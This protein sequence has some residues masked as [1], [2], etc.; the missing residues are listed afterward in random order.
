MK[1]IPLNV[2]DKLLLPFLFYFITLPFF[3][4]AQDELKGK[5]TIYN[6]TPEDYQGEN[7]NWAVTQGEKGVM[8]F[9]NSVGVVAY[10]GYKWETIPVKDKKLIRSLAYDKKN[11]RLYVGAT[12]ELGYISANEKGKLEYQS[13]MP[14]LDTS[15]WDFKGVWQ[16]SV[17]DKG[18]YFRSSNDIFYYHDNQFSVWQGSYSYGDYVDGQYYAWSRR[19]GLMAQVGDSL[20]YVL[21]HEAY[22]LSS[23]RFILPFQNKLLIGT[24]T[25]GLFTYNPKST[26]ASLAFQEFDMGDW[27]KIKNVQIYRGIIL[28]DNHIALA[29]RQSGLFILNQEGKIKSIFDIKAGLMDENVRHA[30]H[31]EGSNQ[32]WLALN[33]GIALVEYNSSIQFFD[34]TFGI[35]GS[36]EE[37]FWYPE[38]GKDRKLYLLGSLGTYR[39]ENGLFRLL[40]SDQSWN[41][42]I[43]K[44]PDESETKL[45]ISCTGSIKEL[46]NDKLQ[47][48]NSSNRG[49]N[50]TLLQSKQYPNKVYIGTLYG[51]TSMRYE[52]GKWINE[53]KVSDMKEQVRDIYEET[54]GDLWLD[55]RFGGPAFIKG[56][57]ARVFGS[58]DGLPSVVDFFQ[59]NEK[60]YFQVEDGFFDYNSSQNAF[61]VVHPFGLKGKSIDI[62]YTDH[63]NNVW[64]SG[65]HSS[66]FF[67]IYKPIS[68]NT[69]SIDSISLKSIAHLNTSI[70]F[71]DKEN[72]TWIV[73]S[74]GLY[75]YEAIDD[76]NYFE[77]HI[78][79][80]N[81]IKTG[82]NKALYHGYG[83]YPPET[84]LNYNDNSV[85]FEY[86]SSY[87]M[88]PENLQFSYQLIGLENSWSDW[89][90]EN[91]KEF[92]NL[93]EG[94]YTFQVKSRNIYNQESDITSYS[95]KIFPPWY[96]TWY[97]YLS[98]F[99]GF[100]LTVYFIVKWNTRRLKL[101]NEKLERVIDERTSEIKTQ[102]EELQLQQDE[103]LA[104]R[105][106]I[107]KQ[108]S[109]LTKKNN[110]V[111]SSINAASI[112]QH[113]ILP[114][115]EI[116]ENCF[117]EHFVIFKPRDIVSGD[118]YWLNKDEETN[119]V[120]IAAIDC[121]GHGVSGALMSMIGYAL[122]DRVSHQTKNTADMLD[123]LSNEL[124]KLFGNEKSSQIV[125]MDVVLISIQTIGQDKCTISYS[126]AKNNLF[127][128][129]ENGSELQ[130]IQGTRKSVG[131]RGK[132]FQ[133][134][135]LELEKGSIL[136]L[137][138]DGFKDQN[139]VKRKKIGKNQL[140]KHLQN[141][142]HLPMSE[143]K[144]AL[145]QV[146]SKHMQ[147]TTQRDDILL[148][149]LKI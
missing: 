84:E 48:V 14:L 144:S 64:I 19:K 45:I 40:D 32:I 108:N 131:V 53:G 98:Y 107:E 30:Y 33:K 5:P 24:Q 37:L 66:P 6:F 127:Y 102:N 121:M 137:A 104:Q 18:V 17:G 90:N 57:S 69:Y 44:T 80:I 46:S 11:K 1:S 31:P 129:K 132:E 95:F 42:L 39:F 101:E 78:T 75:R 38:T 139:D 109:D 106:L 22:P 12:G 16:T 96:R 13:L 50:Y 25:N 55:L 20:E 138:T 34:S 124:V 62:S 89:S 117:S 141:I 148:I 126:G 143:Q 125:T 105:D 86:R 23:I 28:P 54:N 133:F 112:I 35:E 60:L 73:N 93:S 36:I 114:K 147:D 83:E 135:E 130:T 87:Y 103:I 27:E 47:K 128:R 122:F 49:T 9:G 110:I 142:S 149:G 10:D 94:D 136:Y 52:N 76:I 99:L 118:F 92:N 77:K 91:Y 8:Y 15:Y 58:Q 72:V 81:S 88:Y 4:Y 113:A 63:Q 82:K 97:A 123:N 79:T 56:D 74:K 68:E 51:V 2:S 119:T 7:Q 67:S 43:Y 71:V 116:L 120:Y 85:R 61:E 70:L 134:H 29:T 65:N 3:T 115:E 100:V 41:Y 59:Y 140:K 21:G 111:T 145:E 26:D 146:L